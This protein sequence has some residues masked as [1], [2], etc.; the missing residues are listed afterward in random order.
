MHSK[1]SLVLAIALLTPVTSQAV[2]ID[3]IAAI[4]NDDVITQ[5]EV[6]ASEKLNLEFSGLPK[7][8]S[9]LENRIN[10]HLVFQQL[11]NQPPVTISKDEQNRAIQTYIES[12]GGMDK[13]IEFLS[14]IGMNYQD[15]QMGV[16]NQLSVRKFIADRFR[17]FVNVT[18]ADA[19]KYY[20]EV[21]VPIFEVLGKQPPTFPESFEEIQIELVE[22]QVQ[23]RIQEWL[24]EI[25]KNASITVKD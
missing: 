12:H 10:F 20:D 21:Y 14:A 6:Y 24:M 17:P 16:Q 2:V 15:F 8:K 7:A 18:L 13:F 3:K 1:L 5:S 25:R 19:Q 4:V 11:R 23:D 9:A 22:S